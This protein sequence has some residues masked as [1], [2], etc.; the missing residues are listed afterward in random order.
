[1]IDWM[2]ILGWLST[3]LVVL[4][5]VV[6]AKGNLKPALGIWIIADIGWIIYDI[7]IDNYSHMVLSTTIIVINVYGIIR[8][9][10]NGEKFI[11]ENE[12]LD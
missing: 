11:E 1:M 10:L 4:G 7:S 12:R 6:N 2:E 5:Y 8:R 3:A 9:K